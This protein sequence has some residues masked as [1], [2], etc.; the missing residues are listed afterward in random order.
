MHEFLTLALSSLSLDSY[1]IY[2]DMSLWHA[3]LVEYN[4]ISKCKL[5]LICETLVTRV[6]MYNSSIYIYKGSM[7]LQNSLL[8]VFLK[9]NETYEAVGVEMAHSVLSSL[10]VV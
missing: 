2:I 10:C 6:F 4:L 8:N 9:T 1:Q 3:K 5:V 7:Q